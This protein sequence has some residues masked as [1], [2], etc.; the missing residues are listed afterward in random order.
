[1]AALGCAAL[2]GILV[3]AGVAAVLSFRMFA[4]DPAQG[5]QI[6]ASIFEAAYWF[7]LAVGAFVFASGAARARTSRGLAL[8]LL[9]GGVIELAVLAPLIRRHGEGVPIPFALLHA[10]A[11]VVHVLLAISALI[12]AWRMVA[13]LRSPER[14]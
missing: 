7:D 6:A 5:G 3:F 12:L 10:A 11:G 13:A 8:V 14:S 4:Q 9:T 1:V 2:A